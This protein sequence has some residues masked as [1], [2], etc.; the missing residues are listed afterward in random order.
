MNTNI[1]RFENATVITVKD[2]LAGEGVE[3]FGARSSACVAQGV[4]NL[5]VDCGQVGAIDSAGLEALLGLQDK[6]EEQFGS[7]KLCSLDETLVRVLE[8]TRLMRRFEVFED[9]D[10]A[11]RSF[12]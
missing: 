7:A 12:A 3:A 5:V 9:V 2:D 10:A 1:T 8:I 6:C 11:V 4:F